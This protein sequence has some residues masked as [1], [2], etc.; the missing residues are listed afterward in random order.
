MRTEHLM[1]GNTH[2]TRVFLQVGLLDQ[3]KIVSYSPWRSDSAC[4]RRLELHGGG[5]WDDWDVVEGLSKPRAR[6]V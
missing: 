3:M 4:P 6:L 5:P 2:S 1:R